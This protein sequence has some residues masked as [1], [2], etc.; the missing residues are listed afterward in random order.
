MIK[1]ENSEKQIILLCKGHL[2]DKYP[3]TGKWV[4]TLKPLF[5][6]IY[7]WNSDEGDN[8]PNY[9]DVLFNKL[10]DTH[11]K[12]Q[13]DHSSNFRQLREVFDAAFYKSISNDAENPI[14]RAIHT[15]CGHIVCNR[16]IDNKGNKRYDL[17]IE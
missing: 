6:E 10:L 1:L 5:T 12:I 9:L 8:Y 15:L 2:V 3:Y 4:N 7:G 13:E 17:G 16:V 14:E 11:F